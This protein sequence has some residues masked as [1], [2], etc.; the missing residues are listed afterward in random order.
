MY[1]PGTQTEVSYPH[2]VTAEAASVIAVSELE[3][4]RF[5]IL[6]DRTPFHPI[7]P[8]WPDQG[9]DQGI[10]V[11]EGLPFEVLDCVIGATDGADLFIGKDIPVRRGTA[12]WVFV[13]AHILDEPLVVGSS[14]DMVCDAERRHGLS[15]GHTACHV[16]ALALNRV[17]T[18]RWNKEI[19]VDGLGSPDFDQE[20]LDTSRIGINSAVDV[21]R[22]GKSLRK[23]GFNADDLYPEL[24]TLAA[25]AN[26]LLASWVEAAAPVTLEIEGPGVTDKRMWVCELPQGTQRIPCGGTHLGSLGQ[27]EKIEISFSYDE[28]IGKLTMRTAATVLV[29]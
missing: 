2:G 24:L 19:P 1:F 29:A 13:V 14:V 8:R 27:Y 22:L 12:G 18:P 23:K 28:P 25:E 16:A 20:A 10:I 5:A 4:G 9:P 7:D 21:Y 15:A 26:D 17:L 6:T 11:A 3:H